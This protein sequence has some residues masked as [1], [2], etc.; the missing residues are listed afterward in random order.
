MQH[1]PNPLCPDCDAPELDGVGRRDFLRSVG[2]GAVTLASLSSLPAVARARAD[3]KAAPKAAKPAEALIKEL[4][5]SLTSD[6]KTQLVYPWD[7]GAANGKG[8]PT[9][10]RTFNAP[11]FKT[12][13][14]TYTKPQQE[15]VE[16][17]LRSISS[18]EEGYKQISR[19]G[20]FDGSGSLQGCGAYIFGEPADGK[21]YAWVFAGHHLTVRCDGNNE[22]GTAFGGTIYYGHSPNGYSKQNVFS[23][24]TRS[25]ISVFDALSDAQRKKAIVKGTPS[26]GDHSVR[27]RGGS[28]THPGLSFGELNKDQHALVEKV[29]RDLLSPYRKEDVDEVMGIIKAI[30]GMT[31]V[32]LAFYADQRMNDDQPWHL[33]RLEGPGL[34]WNFRV[35]PHVHTWVNISRNA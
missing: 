1:T 25:V 33:W 13:G 24:Q 23:Y 2:G 30:G 16:R 12:V 29:M 8:T 35:L 19:N 3:E 15:L 6:Q 28:A 27:L 7:H 20:R 14:D 26:V 34:A 21:K 32:H 22:D 18:G 17:I 5:T 4:Y 10:L 11:I 9:R 31:Q